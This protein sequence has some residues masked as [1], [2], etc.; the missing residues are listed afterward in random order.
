ML[1]PFLVD[2]SN[3][4]VYIWFV[5]TGVDVLFLSQY[6]PMA[7]SSRTRVFQYLPELEAA[8]LRT[9]VLVVIP[10]SALAA[11][12][13]AG[14]WGRL[15][16]YI[17]ASARTWITG[18]RFLFAARTARVA[19]IQKVLLPLPLA[20]WLRWHRKK[21]LFDFDDAIFTTENPDAGWMSRLR[22]RRHRRLMPAMLKAASAA[23]VE[24][25]YTAGFASTYCPRVETITGPVDTE[26]YRPV[27]LSERAVA[28]LVWIGS[29]TTAAYLEPLRAPLVELGKRYTGL[30]LLVI[31]ATFQV[32]GL[33]VECEP[34]SLETEVALLQACDIGLMPLPDDPWTRGKGGYKILQYS[35]VG[36]PVVASPVGINTTLVEEGVSGLLADTPEAWVT[37]LSHLIDAAALRRR[38]GAEGRSRMLLDYSLKVS[39]RRFSELVRSAHS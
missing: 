33:K 36:L 14:S 26:R 37:A 31:G 15:W 29:P 7:A 6:G 3:F 8:G 2:L 1:T 11:S 22:S 10:D 27:E 12:R 16:Y 25:P 32:D 13:G 38:M 18:I 35:A 9:R 19:L 28:V 5:L 39:A 20:V 23:L 24:N 17:G 21:V 34:W 30:K 4:T